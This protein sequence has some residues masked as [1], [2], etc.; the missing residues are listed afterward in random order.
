MVRF[1]LDETRGEV[2][3]NAYILLRHAV[4]LH[5]LLERHPAGQAADNAGDGHARP[6]DNRLA[7][8]NRG[9][10]LDPAIHRSA[11]S[12]NSSEQ[13]GRRA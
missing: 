6:T 8:L 2:E 4:L 1:V 3:R 11:R 13:S 10:S 5:D 7:V 9:V 12:T